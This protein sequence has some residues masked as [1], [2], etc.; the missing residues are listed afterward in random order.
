MLVHIES[1]CEV[2]AANLCSKLLV[3]LVYFIKFS[4]NDHCISSS[5]CNKRYFEL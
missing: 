2:I 5:N 3:I 4:A 1:S